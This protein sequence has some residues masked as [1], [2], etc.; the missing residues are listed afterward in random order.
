VSVRPY[1][2]HGGIQ[3]FHGDCREILPQISADIVVTDPPYGMGKADWD[4]EIVPVD[5]WLPL[6]K[7]I[8]PTLVFT[9]VKGAFDY[10]RPDWIM[11]WVRAASTQRCGALR[12]FNNWEPILGYNLQAIRNDVISSA[13]LPDGDTGEHPT[14]KPISLMTRLL[15]R[16]EG[17]RVLDPFCGSGTTLIAAKDLGRR[18]IGIEIEEKYCEIAAKRLSQEVFDFGNHVPTTSGQ[19]PKPERAEASTENESIVP[20]VGE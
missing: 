3:I 15:L 16:I 10:P 20:K 6:C 7:A 11:A 19:G 1:Y 13:N 17:Q 5:S 8:G 14:P 4:M 18:A 12:G 2:E 9:G